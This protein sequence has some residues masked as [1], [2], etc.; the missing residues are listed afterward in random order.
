MPNC[1]EA[2][3]WWKGQGEP[4]CCAVVSDSSSH[5][6]YP[7]FC[8][9]GQMPTQARK[10]PCVTWGK[11]TGSLA[12][13]SLAHQGWAKFIEDEEWISPSPAGAKA[14]S[15]HAGA[16]WPG[17]GFAQNAAPADKESLQ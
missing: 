16:Y 12:G 10:Q 5:K 9:A 8:S 17:A 13:E 7:A 6:E 15:S 1:P 4:S 14:Q 11:Y 3:A 2:R